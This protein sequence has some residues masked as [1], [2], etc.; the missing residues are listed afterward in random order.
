MIMRVHLDRRKIISLPTAEAADGT[1]VI[2]GNN[3]LASD[4]SVR[5][6]ARSA[7]VVSG[8]SIQNGISVSSCGNLSIN[9]TIGMRQ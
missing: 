7:S 1:V 4:R 8:V 9:N 3:V 5:V 6:N 2:F